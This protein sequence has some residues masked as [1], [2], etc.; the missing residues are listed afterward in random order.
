MQE[1]GIVEY[2]L[3]WRALKIFGLALVAIKRDQCITVIETGT[4]VSQGNLI[5][6]RNLMLWRIT[7]G[8]RG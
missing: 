8:C 4:F 5:V 6:K 1:F 3:A 7:F 2:I